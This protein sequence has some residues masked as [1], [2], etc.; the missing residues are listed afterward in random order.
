MKFTNEIFEELITLKHNGWR[1]EGSGDNI[2]FRKHF[3][4]IFL[5]PELNEIT[6]NLAVKEIEKIEQERDKYEYRT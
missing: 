5:H 6:Y 1:L 4:K 2:F 3:T